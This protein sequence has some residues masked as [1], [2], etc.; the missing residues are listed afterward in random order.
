MRLPNETFLPTILFLACECEDKELLSSLF[1]FAAAS[2]VAGVPHRAVSFPE[3]YLPVAITAASGS[4]RLF[5]V[6]TPLFPLVTLLSLLFTSLPFISKISILSAPLHTR[7]K[8]R[9]S[10]SSKVGKS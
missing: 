1:V 4:L 8:F 2:F 9:V 5:P 10:Q 6:F 3:Y 7:N